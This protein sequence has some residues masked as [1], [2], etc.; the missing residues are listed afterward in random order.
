MRMPRVPATVALAALALAASLPLTSGAEAAPPGPPGVTADAPAPGAPAAAPAAGSSPADPP[1][2]PAGAARTAAEA[3]EAAGA[4]LVARQGAR[5]RLEFG[6]CPVAEGL[7]PDVRCG[8]LRVPVDY[9]RPFG[10]R[11]EI[12]VSRVAASGA[13]GARRQ[14]ALVYNPGGPGGNGLFFPLVADLPEWR[15]VGAAYDL[16]GYAPRGVG[17]SGRP[18]S[19][20]DPERF[21]RAPAEAAGARPDAAAKETRIA[22]ARSY[23]RGCAERAAPPSARTR[24]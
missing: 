1:P 14:G 20:Q 7:G 4:E 8:T 5:H 6:P 21:D 22:A 19:C 16:V 9:A 2:G 3:A 15:R 11:T 23:A 24:P 12:L 10:P 13:G 17:R 18:L